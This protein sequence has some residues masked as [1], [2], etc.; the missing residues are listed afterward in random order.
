MIN[1]I[2]LLLVEDNP[3]DVELTTHALRLHAPD[4]SIKVARDGVEALQIL[5]IDPG[6]AADESFDDFA[7]L[8]PQVLPRFI[9]LDLKIPLI[10]G[11]EVLK[12]IK[13]SPSTQAIPVIVLST[14]REQRDVQATYDAGVNSY[15]TKPADFQQFNDMIK[16]VANYWLHI[17]EQ[18]KLC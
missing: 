6:K 14:S 17:N 11:V 12:L 5:G 2:D 1:Q 8:T 7:P 3:N 4:L 18:S 16:L 9:L 10:P 13:S 15:L